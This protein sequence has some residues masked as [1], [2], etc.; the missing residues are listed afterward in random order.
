VVVVIL[1]VLTTVW[2]I[3]YESYVSDSRDS[4]RLALLSELRNSLRI[5]SVES[6]IPLPDDAIEFRQDGNVFSYQW[7]VWETVLESLELSTLA[8]DPK[9]D[10]YFTYLATKDRDTFQLMGYLENDPTEDLIS[11]THNSYANINYN[12]RFP[13][14]FGNNL[15]VILSEDTQEPIQEV[16]PFRTQGFV[17]FEL[18]TSWISLLAQIWNNETLRWSPSDFTGLIPLSTCKTLLLN[19]K[20]VSGFYIINP[21]G[22]RPLQVYCDMVTDG[23][24]W[25]FTTFIS[26][27]WWNLGLFAWEAWQYRADRAVTAKSYSL[28]VSVIPHD[29]LYFVRTSPDVTQTLLDEREVFYME[30][31]NYKTP[32]FSIPYVSNTNYHMRFWFTW[33]LIS[34]TT[35]YKRNP[36]VQYY[37][38]CIRKPTWT[39]FGMCLRTDGTFAYP[40]DYARQDSVFY[41]NENT[42]SS[43]ETAENIWYYVR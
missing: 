21:T 6:Q 14:V 2:F 8:I 35:Y 13:T 39:H 29:A 25:T 27:G 26:K 18:D 10:T 43:G 24:G 19:G 40:N 9:D 15:G 5:Y 41:S 7:Y 12:K 16:E 1:S 4:K 17:D 38:V 36:D 28:D 11:V 37:Q 34:N 22:I 23:W 32:P 31:D 30:I 42:G 20:T 33:A 3:A